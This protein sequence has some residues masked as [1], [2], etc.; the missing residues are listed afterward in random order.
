MHCRIT[1]LFL[2]GV[3]C[4]LPGGSIYAVE[5]RGAGPQATLQGVVHPRVL[6]DASEVAGVACDGDGYKGFDVISSHAADAWKARDLEKAKVLKVRLLRELDEVVEKLRQRKE[7]Y[8]DRI[9]AP[10][11]TRRYP[12]AF[13][14]L[15]AFSEDGRNIITDAEAD[16][17]EERLCQIAAFQVPEQ[18]YLP[19]NNITW[20]MAPWV[21][22]AAAL[23][24]A[25]ARKWK[26][27]DPASGKSVVIAYPGSRA[28]MAQGV[29]LMERIVTAKV[30]DDMDVYT[31]SPTGEFNGPVAYGVG[32]FELYVAAWTVF[33][34]HAGVD[35]LARPQV[36]AC[37]RGTLQTVTPPIPFLDGKRTMPAIG[38][39]ATWWNPPL[40]LPSIVYQIAKSDPA[41]A[42]ECMTIAD[43]SPIDYGTNDLTYL[44]PRWNAA[45][46]A[47]AKRAPATLRP[48]CVPGM[49][50]SVVLRWNSGS[51]DETY[52][53]CRVPGELSMKHSH[54][55]IG[56]PNIFVGGIPVVVDSG[57]FYGAE[58]K[59]SRPEGNQWKSLAAHSALSFTSFDQKNETDPGSGSGQARS[60]TP[61][62]V[63]TSGTLQLATV[64]V[65]GT[66]KPGGGPW[67]PRYR[68]TI[69]GALRGHAIFAIYDH[70]ERAGDAGLSTLSNLQI[71]G[72]KPARVE[73][74]RA[75]IDC[76][77]ELRLEA[78]FVLP[79]NGALQ[80]EKGG[81]I[82]D[83]PVNPWNDGS[84]RVVHPTSW[85]QYGQ[86][87]KSWTPSHLVI[88]QVLKK[89]EV[90]PAPVT[91]IPTPGNLAVFQIGGKGGRIL[92][93]ANQ[94]ETKAVWR[95]PFS[96]G[97]T[98]VVGA[99]R[100]SA[101]PE[102]LVPA[103]GMM[104]WSDETVIPPQ[105]RP[106]NP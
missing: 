28:L 62:Q 16:H 40:V 91:R 55:D 49:G 80:V 11:S 50:R 38:D 81:V 52:L 60:G 23:P 64:W 24:N 12:L 72:V 73:Q 58:R 67:A 4:V 47:A 79:E 39:Q 10:E 43:V 88:L 48:G 103:G 26:M 93:V 45:Q 82:T 46:R 70:V 56:S 83:W 30:P 7:W 6:F 22:T 14:L 100:E 78:S 42:A 68:R 29:A 34:R 95:P 86:T 2:L 3:F 98:E 21:F 59:A 27:D 36:K 33:R 35:F 20:A 51:A 69:A 92:V 61:P 74:S 71:A 53:M 1:R 54:D 99:A 102:L 90:A 25:P 44:M 41:L 77:G 89:G 75:V 63:E 66:T 17:I 15:A 105:S 9:R 94:G 65:P 32:A 13:D 97:H 101:G 57:W 5:E 8:H 37:I 87:A 76:L 96:K 106:L 85:L 19:T 84:G 104:L 18:P 31:V